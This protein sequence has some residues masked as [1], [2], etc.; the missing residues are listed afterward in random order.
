[1]DSRVYMAGLLCPTVLS[2]FQAS[3]QQFSPSIRDLR[4]QSWRSAR[5]RAP[6]PGSSCWV[7]PSCCCGAKSSLRTPPAE[8]AASPPQTQGASFSRRHCSDTSKSWAHCDRA[9]SFSLVPRPF[10]FWGTARERV[11]VYSGHNYRGKKSLK[12]YTHFTKK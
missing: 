8:A 4:Q 3:L 5:R 11:Y 9:L 7:R 12:D 6:S 2:W 1:M 10:H